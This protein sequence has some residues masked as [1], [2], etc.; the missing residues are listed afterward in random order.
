MEQ[1]AW[2]YIGQKGRTWEM[3]GSICRSGPLQSG[4]GRC[5]QVWVVELFSFHRCHQSSRLSSQSLVV[6]LRLLGHLTLTL[7]LHLHLRNRTL[8]I[9]G[10]LG[11]DQRTDYFLIYYKPF[12]ITAEFVSGVSL[13]LSLNILRGMT[14]CQRIN[15]T[16][17]STSRPIRELR[18]SVNYQ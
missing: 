14:E 17:L 9:V 15:G 5:Q 13:G 16:H 3:E 1:G 12:S 4:G 2:G 6:H 10:F 8:E 18:G 7:S 11:K